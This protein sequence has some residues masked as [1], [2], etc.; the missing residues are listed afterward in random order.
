MHD[1]EHAESFGE[2]VITLFALRWLR[3]VW[4]F[5]PP[6]SFVALLCPDKA[7]A[8]LEVDRFKQ[9]CEDFQT[10]KHSSRQPASLKALLDRS[11]CN[12]ASVEQLRLAL[13]EKGWDF[14][15]SEIQGLLHE[16]FSAIM[17]TQSVEDVN[18]V[19]KKQRTRTGWGGRYRRPQT[20]MFSA[21]S[22]G[23]LERSHRFD[24][25]RRAA[26][27]GGCLEPLPETAFVAKE[28]ASMNFDAI[29]TTSQSSPYFSPSAEN[30][31]V[32]WCDVALMREM[33]ATSNHSLINLCWQGFWCSS[34]HG[35]IFQIRRGDEVLLD[36]HL[37]LHHFGDSAPLA[38][39]VILKRPPGYNEVE[40]ATFFDIGEGGIHPVVIRDLGEV[41]AQQITW[42]S[43]PW[44]LQEYPAAQGHWGAAARGFLHSPAAPVLQVAARA[45]WWK[46][47]RG[48]LDKI[49][50]HLGI[51][52]AQGVDIFDLLWQVTAA[53]LGPQVSDDAILEC[54]RGRLKTMA[55]RTQFSQELLSID[56]AAGCLEEGDQVELR[57]QQHE[58]RD[59]Q[60]EERCFRDAYKTKKATVRVST[61]RTPAAKRAAA[62][63]TWKGP[64]KLPV[65]AKISQADAKQL[66]PPG[67]LKSWP[68]RAT[69]QGAWNTRV[70]E[71]LV[72]SRS[73]AANGGESA[74][75]R[76]VIQDAWRQWLTLQGFELSDCPI[77]GMLDLV[78][79]RPTSRAAAAASASSGSRRS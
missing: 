59:R 36:W 74:A 55:K 38:V 49:G 31:G 35:L 60:K 52:C 53:A 33:V 4:M 66:M 15:D 57:Q 40:E 44:Q 65:F 63:V 19:Q 75:L 56:E 18:H 67:P 7:V 62:K 34:N 25:L 42:R 54:L 21:V 24:P 14:Q 16:R 69:A 72:C 6:I 30:I 70:S 5:L 3:C 1:N 68:W 37:A 73:D 39:L 58:A 43:W 17:T 77:E 13:V 10:L 48:V 20:S 64:V 46:L 11:C 22:S 61:A 71:L 28:E 32:T 45:G 50:T 8:Q 27:E 2:M 79:P 9:M 23:I 12:L 47:G 26:I 78:D 51:D 41:V 76:L 29:V